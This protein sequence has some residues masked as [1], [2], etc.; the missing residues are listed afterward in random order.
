MLGF[1]SESDGFLNYYGETGVVAGYGFGYLSDTAGS[2]SIE[3]DCPGAVGV[4]PGVSADAGPNIVHWPWHSS[5]NVF[6]AGFTPSI[7]EK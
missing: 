3:A 2:P 6:G 7:G 5:I 4:A 1:R